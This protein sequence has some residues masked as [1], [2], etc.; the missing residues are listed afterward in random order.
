MGHC[1]ASYAPYVRQGRSVVVS[2]A[3]PECKSLF[4]G[5]LRSTVEID[6]GRGGVMQHKGPGNDVPHDLC[7]AAL[8]VCLRRWGLGRS[9]R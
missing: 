1:V 7:E 6:R 9:A 3:V 5:T 2:I 4:V 8:R